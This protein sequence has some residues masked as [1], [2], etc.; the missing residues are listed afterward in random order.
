MLFIQDRTGIE[1]QCIGVDF[2]NGIDGVR[3]SCK[4]TKRNTAAAWIISCSYITG[5]FSSQE[6][7]DI[8]KKKF[9][10]RPASI[11]ESLDLLRPI[12]RKSCN[13]GHFGRELPEFTWEKTD[14]AE[15]LKQAVK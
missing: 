11:I 4:T 7:T 1:D 14:M 2:T 9:Y 3:P 10:L 5:V 15:E 8:V 13:Y 12:Y 6:L